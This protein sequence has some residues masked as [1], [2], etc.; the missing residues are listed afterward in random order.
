[1]VNQLKKKLENSEKVFGTFFTAGNMGT[2]ECLGYTG[3]DFVA[4]H[5]NCGCIT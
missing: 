4:Y 5:A 1:M 2:M 3:L